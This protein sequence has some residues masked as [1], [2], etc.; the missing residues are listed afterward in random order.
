MLGD[1]QSRCKNGI[2]CYALLHTEHR[3][4]GEQLDCGY[5]S[6]W[7]QANV[8]HFIPRDKNIGEIFGELM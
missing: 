6:Y 2:L 5:E 7:G 8:G 3:D 1:V 4:S